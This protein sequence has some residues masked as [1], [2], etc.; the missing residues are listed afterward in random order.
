MGV[1]EICAGRKTALLSSQ[2]VYPGRCPDTPAI[3]S[4]LTGRGLDLG[5]RSGTMRQC[6]L[7]QSQ[8]KE[9]LSVAW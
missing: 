6:N 2:Q 1:F 4:P 8:K 5:S 9:A 7:K 3:R